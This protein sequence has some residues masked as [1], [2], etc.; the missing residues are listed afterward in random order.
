MICPKCG[1][2]RGDWCDICKLGMCCCT[3]PIYSEPDAEGRRNIQ[4]TKENLKKHEDDQ[5]T[6]TR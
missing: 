3:L 4:R 6:Q 1:T 2:E 5:Q